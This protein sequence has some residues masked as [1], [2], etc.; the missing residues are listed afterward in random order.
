MRWKFE[1]FFFKKCRSTAGALALIK[2]RGNYSNHQ[3][4]TDVFVN[5]RV[6]PD[7]E[8]TGGAIAVINDLLAF[9][10]GHCCCLA[11]RN[12]RLFS[13]KFSAMADE[14]DLFGSHRIFLSN[15]LENLNLSKISKFKIWRRKQSR[16]M[17]NNNSFYVCEAFGQ[18][19]TT[20]QLF[21]DKRVIY[22]DFYAAT[23]Q[24]GKTL[25]CKRRQMGRVWG[26][27][28]AADFR[29]SN[30]WMGR[31]FSGFIAVS[32]VQNIDRSTQQLPFS[33]LVGWFREI[34]W[35]ISKFSWWLTDLKSNDLDLWF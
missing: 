29:P 18:F 20:D 5:S 16:Q 4:H 24:M 19:I 34:N 25:S 13:T 28:C 1:Y 15:W 32:F 33:S 12:F 17:D 9:D 3:V 14:C 35:N 21:C 26:G 6:S 7:N 2:R 10:G 22:N 11:R 23:R 27:R 8:R 31:R 30:I